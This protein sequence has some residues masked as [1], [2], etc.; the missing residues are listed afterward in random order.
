MGDNETHILN[1]KLYSN[2]DPNPNPIPNPIY[3]LIPI[4]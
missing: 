1:A 2:T 4:P 3:N